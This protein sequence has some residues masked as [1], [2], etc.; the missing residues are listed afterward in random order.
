VILNNVFTYI[1]KVFLCLHNFFSLNP[2]KSLGNAAF[3]DVQTEQVMHIL[4][5]CCKK[6]QNQVKMGR[7]YY[8]FFLFFNEMSILILKTKT[9]LHFILH[10]NFL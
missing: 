4:Q 7:D 2:S 1:D 6:Q 8:Y 10:V 3:L 5:V 9:S